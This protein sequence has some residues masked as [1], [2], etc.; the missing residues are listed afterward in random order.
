MCFL[1]GRNWVFISHETAFFIVTAVETSTH[2]SK[3]I[4]KHQILQLIKRITNRV[5]KVPSQQWPARLRVTFVSWDVI[6]AQHL[7]ARQ[8]ANFQVQWFIIS[9]PMACNRSPIARLSRVAILHGSLASWQPK[10]IE[11]I[12]WPIMAPK[13]LQDI[14]Q[15]GNLDCLEM[16]TSTF[17]LSHAWIP[18]PKY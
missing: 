7:H 17:L 1:W 3:W 2:S 12:L 18:K 13:L 15:W 10:E 8:A 16:M 4:I 6:P 14:E 5:K 9:T 11:G